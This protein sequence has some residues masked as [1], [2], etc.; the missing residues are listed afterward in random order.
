MKK[1]NFLVAVM[2]VMLI[3]LS[4]IGTAFATEY[5][6]IDPDDQGKSSLIGGDTLAFTDDTVWANLTARWGVRVIFQDGDEWSNAELKSELIPV[7]DSA[8]GSTTTPDDP[9]H[10]GW[11]F[12]GWERVDTNNG[13]STLNDDGTVTGI[14]GP[15][16][17]IYQA[18]YEPIPPKTGGLTVSKT[19]SG[20]A[21][22]ATHAFTFTV[23]LSDTTVS[24]EFGDMAF[25]EGIA[26]FKLKGGERITAEGL[27]AGASYVVVESDNRGYRI[28]K[29][30]D[31]GEIVDGKTVVAAFTNIRNSSSPSDSDDP[32][33]AP[34]IGSLTI[35]KTV[36]GTASDMDKA[37]TFTVTFSSSGTYSYTGSKSGTI[38]SGGTVQLKDGES[39]TISGIPADTSYMVAESDNE[40]YEVYKSG[41]T[42]T[43]AANSTSTA[44]F[45]NRHEAAPPPIDDPNKSDA[46]DERPTDPFKPDNP[47]KPNKPVTPPTTSNPPN[48]PG[49]PNQPNEPCTPDTPSESVTPQTGDN[50]NMTLWLG[51]L[52]TSFGGMIVCLVLFRKKKHVG[53]HTNMLLILMLV[54]II[55]FSGFSATNAF[56]AED[57]T[58]GYTYGQYDMT[59]LP[60]TTDTVTNMPENETSLTP[61]ANNPYT[62]SSTVPMREGFEFID[63]TLTWGTMEKPIPLTD[64]VVK[65]LDIDTLE[66]VT[67]DK[68][69]TGL[70]VGTSVNENAVGVD[71]YTALDPTEA[72]LVLAENGNE[73]IFYYKKQPVLTSYTIYY[74]DANTEEMISPPKIKTN[75]PIGDSITEYAVEVSDYYPIGTSINFTTKESGNEYKFYYLF[76]ED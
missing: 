7:T 19:I 3:L 73:I 28:T 2:L 40:G 11:T 49:T 21:A 51:I 32:P 20:D 18:V 15:G 24:G 55:A 31:T 34:K 53:N 41:D 1:K 25:E 52:L 72:T 14:N 27:P 30:G 56:A 42:G 62:I 35:S 5:S 37:F 13:S 38:H 47:D 23:T 67:E 75:V 9:I 22:D 57:S 39:I 76:K 69:V 70:E 33:V 16:P 59:Y 6:P 26:T 61:G 48:D 45:R 10:E 68:T 64:Y 74:L 12:N 8:A 60:G 43:I 4:T 50:S 63:W 65:Y 54:G 29:T 17:I 71:G 58:T 46:P 36:L 66:P 44:S